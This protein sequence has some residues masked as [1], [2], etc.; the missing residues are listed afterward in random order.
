M[1][2]RSAWGAGAGG[3]VSLGG[4]GRYGGGVGL[5]GGNMNLGTGLPGDGWWLPCEPPMF[6]GARF[7]GEEG[8]DAGGEGGGR[9]ASA[10]SGPADGSR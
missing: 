8:G 10:R 3:A 4:V 7:S 1:C 5:C 6:G 9:F 2:G